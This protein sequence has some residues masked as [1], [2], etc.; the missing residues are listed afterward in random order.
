MS[1]TASGLP[2][3]VT[4]LANSVVGLFVVVRRVASVLAPL[5]F[6]IARRSVLPCPRPWDGAADV[7]A[8]AVVAGTGAGGGGRGAGDLRATGTAVAGDG[9]GSVG[10]VFPD[11][12][13]AAAFGVRGRP[14]WSPGR[15]AL[16]TV[17]QLSLIHI[18]EPTRPY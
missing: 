3:T 2:Y 5:G 14:G 8:A 10:E 1:H 11:A 17:L 16:V 6:M 12:E 9:A 7:R 18:S 4:L 13:F 15:L